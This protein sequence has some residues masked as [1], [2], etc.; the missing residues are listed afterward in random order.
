MRCIP[1]IFSYNYITHET[2]PEVDEAFKKAGFTVFV[3]S[4]VNPDGS[5]I[6]CKKLIDKIASRLKSAEELL[7]EDSEANMAVIVHFDDFVIFD[8]KKLKT[9]LGKEPFIIYVHAERE[10]RICAFE[11]GKLVE[12]F[13]LTGLMEPESIVG[14]PIC[15]N[16]SPERSLHKMPI[17]LSDDHNVS[18][19]LSTHERWIEFCNE[20]TC[21]GGLMRSYKV[22]DG[23]DDGAI[24][25]C[26]YDVVPEAGVKYC[27]MYGGAEAGD[28]MSKALA[29][30]LM[31]SGDTAIATYDAVAIL[32]TNMFLFMNAEVCGECL[33]SAEYLVS[34]CASDEEMNNFVNSR[35]YC[36]LTNN[37]N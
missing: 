22:R 34:L 3:A 23:E 33:E 30:S 15:V 12:W 20:Q 18:P 13:R 35:L 26:Y 36:E 1:V 21:K 5:Y 32:G 24:A 10:S 27:V 31:S 7:K 28:K 29:S 2:V 37:K 14:C 8:D 9:L 6:S 25:R 11:D 17:V 19:V 16:G 4:S